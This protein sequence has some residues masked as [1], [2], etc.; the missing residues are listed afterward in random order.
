MSTDENGSDEWL[1][2]GHLAKGWKLH[3][4]STSED[5]LRQ[6]F[7]A[8]GLTPDEITKRIRVIKFFRNEKD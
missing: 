5:E 7:A 6:Q 3:I 4:T 1:P 8:D 2:T